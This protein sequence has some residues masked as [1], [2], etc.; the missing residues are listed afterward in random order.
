MS[1]VG[2]FPKKRPYSLLNCEV[3]KYPTCWLAPVASIIADNIRR[4]ASWRRN[5]FWYCK[6]LI[7]VTDL[8]C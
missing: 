3:L 5:T 1:L 8:K 6:G 4:L 7:D 2:A